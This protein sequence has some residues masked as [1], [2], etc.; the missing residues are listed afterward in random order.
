MSVDKKNK[1]ILFLLLTVKE[2]AQDSEK[3]ALQTLLWLKSLERSISGRKEMHRLAEEVTW[4]LSL[5]GDSPQHPLADPP[6][7][8]C[9]SFYSM[10]LNCSGSGD[11]AQ[12]KK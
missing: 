8:T 2:A 12:E 6:Q 5:N 1:G 4:F 7:V 11:G 3:K 10:D 9:V